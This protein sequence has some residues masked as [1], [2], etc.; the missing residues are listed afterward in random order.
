MTIFRPKISNTE[1]VIYDLLDELKVKV[2]RRT[3]FLDLKA[4]PRYPDLLAISDCLTELKVQNHIYRKKKEEYNPSDLKFPFIAH[5]YAGQ[6]RFGVI[7]SIK[8]GEV[9]MSD[10]RNKKLVISEFD[11]LQTWDGIFLYAQS[12]NQS[13]Q[14]NYYFNRIQSILKQIAFPTF[15][16]AI[17]LSLVFFSQNVYQWAALT[18][19]MIKL[20]GL[21][22]SVLLLILG[23]DK[24]HPL[25]SRLC[26][27]E[28]ESNCNTILDTDASKITPWLN[29]SDIGFFYY[30]G[31]FL[32]SLIFPMLNPV[33]AWINI[34]ALPFLIYSLQYQYMNKRWCPLCCIILL[35]LVSEFVVYQLE[36]NI[37]SHVSNINSNIVVR[38]I[39]FFLIP[40]ITWGWLKS[41]LIEST[42]LKNEY[43]SLKAIKYDPDLFIQALT[44]QQ[45]YEINEQLMPVILGNSNSDRAITLVISPFCKPCGDTFLYVT[46]WLRQNRSV[47]IKLL[48]F[49]SQTD[50]DS[51]SKVIQHMMA[52]YFL[53][54]QGKFFEAMNDWFDQTHKEYRIWAEKYAVTVDDNIK[55]ACHEQEKWC[56]D[57][58]ISYTP[59]VLVNG[60]QLS[61]LYTIKDLKYLID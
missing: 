53:G 58:K 19:C 5:F 16:I 27:N 17:F 29:W 23:I 40:M 25:V 46:E 33:L 3:I 2:D 21:I 20:I 61:H 57:I 12:N 59:T 44:N 39:L 60:Y 24:D 8:N 6:G 28:K 15:L 14:H 1:A 50:N 34:I 56:D 26:G 47:Q 51:R 49:N 30:I 31:T 37:F 13:G 32:S 42:A 35:C 38:S 9:K 18:I 4:H 36:Y 48:F 45:R 41:I 55:K 22:V 43:Q 7:Y 54:D 10:E 11:F 52:L